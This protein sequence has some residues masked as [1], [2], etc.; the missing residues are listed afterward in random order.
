MYTGRNSYQ[1]NYLCLHRQS[2]VN[3]YSTLTQ[4]IQKAEKILKQYK[5]ISSIL[6]YRFEDWQIGQLFPTTIYNTSVAVVWRVTQSS[7]DSEV[8]L[9]TFKSS[10]SQGLVTEL[11]TARVK[12]EHLQ[13]FGIFTGYKTNKFAENVLKKNSHAKPQVKQEPAKRQKVEDKR[14]AIQKAEKVI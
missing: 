8:H 2:C 9:S 7:S 14:Q 10:T 11:I 6:I 12:P 5:D 3:C 13:V 1:Q 4:A